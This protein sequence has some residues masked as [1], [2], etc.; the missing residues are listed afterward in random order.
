MGDVREFQLGGQ[1]CKAVFTL[2]GFWTI[3]FRRETF[4][5]G[6]VEFPVSVDKDLGKA[7]IDAE[8]SLK[9]LGLR[10]RGVHE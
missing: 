2:N 6:S 10:R 4:L 1:S 3:Y 9:I 7:I 8:K 5:G